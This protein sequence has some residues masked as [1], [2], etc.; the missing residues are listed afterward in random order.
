MPLGDSWKALKG[1]GEYDAE[2]YFI[3]QMFDSKWEPSKFLHSELC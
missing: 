2:V 3:S 1:S